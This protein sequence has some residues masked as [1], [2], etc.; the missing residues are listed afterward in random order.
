MTGHLSFFFLSRERPLDASRMDGRG[1]SVGDP[2]SQLRRPHGRLARLDGLEKG[3]DLG[4]QFVA[5][6]R[7]ALL[8]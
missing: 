4:R 2:A 3:D 7:P 6:P 1:K 5:A 8:R